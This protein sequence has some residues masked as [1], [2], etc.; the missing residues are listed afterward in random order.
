M[1]SEKVHYLYFAYGSNMSFSQMRTRCPNSKFIGKACLKDFE[2]VFDGHSYNRG[3]AVANVIQKRECKVEGGLFDITE[4][5]LK[6]LDQYEGYPSTYDREELEV[7]DEKGTSSP[8]LI[9]KRTGKK[10]GKP[11]DDYLKTIIDGARNCGLSEQY[12]N[13]VLRKSEAV[14]ANCDHRILKQKGILAHATDSPM[15]SG[16]KVDRSASGNASLECKFLGCNCHKPEEKS[17]W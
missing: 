11:S 4:S 16:G 12:I 17:C 9:Y 14:C 3:G 10:I 5:D 15:H 2:F 13:V 6:A 8:A 1:N 7:S